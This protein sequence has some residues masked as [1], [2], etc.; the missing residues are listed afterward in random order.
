MEKGIQKLLRSL[1]IKKYPIFLDVHVAES[2]RYHPNKI[3]CYE[4]FL[5]T[6][7]DDWKKI[8]NSDAREVKAFIKNLAKYMDVSI[9]GIYADLVTEEEWEEMK[10][11]KKD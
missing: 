5:T 4:V 7:D 11:D 9:C 8:E 6:F 10:S 2:G 1:V 3:I